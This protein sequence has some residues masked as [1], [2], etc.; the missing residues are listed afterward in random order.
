MAITRTPLRYPG[1]KS[2]ALDVLLP[3]MPEF[4][5][6][7]EPFL[8][9]GS[10]LLAAAQRKPE[11]RFWGADLNPDVHAFWHVLKDDAKALITGVQA[12]YDRAKRQK[13]GRG[14]HRVMVE[15]VP[16]DALERAVRFFVLNRITFSGTIEAGGF[17]QSA[18]EKRF[19]QSSIER[20]APVARLLA[21]TRITHGDY[22][23]VVK[24]KGK[25]VFI[26][27]DP[28][29]LSATKSRLYGKNG[30]LHTGFDHERFARIMRGV[31]HKWLITYDDS[32]EV[33]KLF[34]F[35][36]QREWTLQYGMNNFCQE[37]AAAGKELLLANYELPAREKASTRARRSAPTE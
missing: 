37:S 19:T 22:E 10:M 33:R 12:I 20:L 31:K 34:P 32:P 3:L 13:S 4:D 26:F 11:A 9:G 35:A 1:G 15:Q 16:Q 7:R 6:F 2:K 28:P 27:L 23:R 21:R 30:A 5:E 8:G 24:A 17:S 14:L 25:R 36:H 18:F 29:Y